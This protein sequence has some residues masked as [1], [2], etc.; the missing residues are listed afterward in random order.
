[1]AARPEHAEARTEEVAVKTEDVEAKVV[2]EAKVEAPGMSRTPQ[3]AAATAITGMV[4]LLGTVS[5]P[6]PAPGS[7]RWQPS[8]EP[9]TTL[10]RIV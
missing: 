8:H 2:R 7:P 1:M 4:L 10:G 5:S 6:C 3:R 9:S